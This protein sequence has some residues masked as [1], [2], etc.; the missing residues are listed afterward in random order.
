M[1]KAQII[2]ASGSEPLSFAVH[3]SEWIQIYELNYLCKYPLN[4]YLYLI[5][6]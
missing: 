5:I 4:P 1:D 6:L 3:F 2:A